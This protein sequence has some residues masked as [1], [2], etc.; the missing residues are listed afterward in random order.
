[1][2]TLV[3]ILLFSVLT[4][5]VSGLLSFC[6]TMVSMLITRYVPSIH[7]DS[8]AEPG[9]VL[10]YR[11]EMVKSWSCRKK[12]Q[13][14]GKLVADCGFYIWNGMVVE[15][16]HVE[17]GMDRRSNTTMTFWGPSSQIEK[18]RPRISRDDE[19]EMTDIIRPSIWDAYH[20]NVMVPHG[21]TV[22]TSAQENVCRDI[23]RIF[24]GNRRMAGRKTSVLAF[25]TGEPGSGKSSIVNCL[26]SLFHKRGEHPRVL[27]MPLDI[28]SQ[29]E[30]SDRSS[31]HSPLIACVDE[32]ESYIALAYKNDKERGDGVV[33]NKSAVNRVLSSIA[34]FCSNVI[35]VATS[36][37][38]VE[39]LLKMEEGWRSHI[40]RFNVVSTMNCPTEGEMEALYLAGCSKFGLQPE[41][42]V[43]P[44]N[45]RDLWTKLSESPLAH[46]NGDVV[47]HLD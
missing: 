17:G 34:E 12:V 18:V 45:M 38:P 32:I 26:V 3:G 22:L 46:R 16:S 23:L 27:R 31:E 13:V 9:L 20:S 44:R 21:I 28:F 29:M 25:V 41:H 33:W 11:E 5:L 24:D 37:V 4:A 19:F 15:I 6:R 10:T 1:M 30:I 35:F 42:G 2:E 47:L 39:E 8:H 14:S 36:N 43:V 7:I 40:D